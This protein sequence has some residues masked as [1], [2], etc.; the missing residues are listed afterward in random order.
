MFDRFS[1]SARTVIAA[2]NKRSLGFEHD[3]IGSE[4]LL[5][6][7]L[8]VNDDLVDGL[9]AHQAI[10]KE[11][12]VRTLEGLLV[13]GEGRERGPLPFTPQAKDLLVR[14]T[15]VA[16][17]MSS[18]TVEPLHLLQAMMQDDGSVAAQ[19]LIQAGWDTESAKRW[20]ETRHRGRQAALAPSPP[21]SPPMPPSF[22]ARPAFEKLTDRSRRVLWHS[23]KIAEEKG[24]TAI[25]PA[26]LLAG[27][28]HER[29]GVAVLALEEAGVARELSGEGRM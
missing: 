28:T 27:L 23:H 24:G 4:H 10:F 12:I 11:S 17:R 7:L 16:Q 15:E 5:L 2:A 25:T 19:V 18:S 26:I 29:S 14:S 22:A 21:P 1:T 8:S 20:A 9:L 6:G 13:H 3:Y